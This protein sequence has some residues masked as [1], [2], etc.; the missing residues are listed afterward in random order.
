M[1]T[2]LILSLLISS[3]FVLTH[4]INLSYR[5][6]YYLICSPLLLLWLILTYPSHFSPHVSLHRIKKSPKKFNC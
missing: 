1:L 3:Y 2:Y 6:L 4:L 5:F